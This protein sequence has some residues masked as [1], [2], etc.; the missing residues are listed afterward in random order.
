[1]PDG[2]RAGK[3][4]GSELAAELQAKAKQEAKQ[5]AMLGTHLTGQ[6]ADT[7]S[8][9]RKHVATL[10]SAGVHASRTIHTTLLC[11]GH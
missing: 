7:V 5:F 9:E 10:I 4:T 11:R 1:M 2:G 6:G 3:V 8:A